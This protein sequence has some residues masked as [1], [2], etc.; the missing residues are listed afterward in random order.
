MRSTPLLTARRRS[1]CVGC[2]APDSAR[3]RAVCTRSC[4][5][6]V[7]ALTSGGFVAR[8]GMS[9]RFRQRTLHR[10]VAEPRGQRLRPEGGEVV[11]EVA[12]L[13]GEDGGGDALADERPGWRSVAAKRTSCPWRRGRAA[14]RRP[15]RA[16][17]SWWASTGRAR[18]AARPT[19]AAAAG[20]AGTAATRAGK[21]RRRLDSS[22]YASAGWKRSAGKREA[23]RPRGAAVGADEPSISGRE[24]TSATLTAGAAAPAG[25]VSIT[26]SGPTL[27]ILSAHSDHLASDALRGENQERVAGSQAPLAGHRAA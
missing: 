17:R 2:G 16:P 3:R 15:G 23:A 21:R 5:F 8:P 9:G 13:G 12:A 18:C 7:Q 11:V 25:R 22:W 4:G 27:A 10:A 6:T 14:M 20:S 1:A 19:S 26:I 24:A